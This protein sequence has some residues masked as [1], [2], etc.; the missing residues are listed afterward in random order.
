[1]NGL[2]QAILVSRLRDRAVRRIA[3]YSLALQTVA[4]LLPLLAPFAG[5]AVSCQNPPLPKN[6]LGGTVVRV[7]D[8][9]TAYIRFGGRSERVRFIGIDTPEVYPGEKL[10]RDARQLG[11]SRE[12]VQ[13]LGRLASEYTKRH[14]AEATVRLELDVEKRDQYGRLLAYV[15]LGD[16]TLFNA[17]IVQDGY[18]LVYTFPPNVKYVD[19][20]LACQ[21]E[22]REKGNGLWFTG[23]LSSSAPTSP[24][25]AASPARCD[26]AYPDVCIPSPPPDLDCADISFR[27][28]RVFPPDPH[29]FDGDG[30]GIGCER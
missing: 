26:P 18:A 9:D 22:A 25:A 13:D 28:F 27:R 3:R 8:G 30:D 17:K 19:V 14:L 10:N 12:V 2:A 21:R 4:L 15:W 16:A 1:M 20:F 24:G 23:L 6:L 5:P 29:R 11:V 7:V